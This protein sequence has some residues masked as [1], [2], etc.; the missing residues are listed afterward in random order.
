MRT[1]D[2]AIENRLGLHARPASDFV[3]CARRFESE[4]YVSNATKRDRLFDAKSPMHLLAANL[5]YGDVLHIE[6]EGPD[7]REA[8][9]A[10][11]EVV[12]SA[13]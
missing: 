4:I 10:L 6:A 13:S 8:V 11:V 3:A 12:R 9:E 5:A 7:E 2:L 1:A